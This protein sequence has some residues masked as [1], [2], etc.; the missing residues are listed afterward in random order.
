MPIALAW[1]AFKLFGIWHKLGGW[2]GV[3]WGWVTA[4]WS[5]VLLV[6]LAVVS[7]YALHEH[8]AA[9]GWIT[10]YDSHVAADKAA[11]AENH[12]AQAA[13][14]ANQGEVQAERN[15]RTADVSKASETARV[16]AVA[17]YVRSHRLRTGTGGLCTAPAAHL[18]D[19]SGKPDGPTEVAS[20]VTIT[21]ADLDGLTQ[22]AVQGAV[23]LR[24]LESLV[25]SG[26][27]VVVPDTP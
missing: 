26:Q 14:D 17:D 19:D 9:Q 7:L 12:R 23:R 20:V 27:A 4:S 21:T 5:H 16:G 8:R 25:T 13:Q 15:R 22:D 1:Q 3:A 24:F 2:F 18:P 10:A 11:T 6:A